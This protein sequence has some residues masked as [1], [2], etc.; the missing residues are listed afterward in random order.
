MPTAR[1]GDQLLVRE[2]NLSIILNTLSND[3]PGSRAALAAKT[4]LNKTTASSLVS[5][6]LKAQ[7]VRERGYLDSTGGRPGLLLELNRD[8][9]GIIA[10]EIGVDFVSVILANF[11]AEILWR[12][13]EP[14]QSHQSQKDILRR[15]TQLIRRA[16]REGEHSCA[17]LLGLGLG[18]P[19]LV[20]VGSGALVFAPNLGWR[21]VPLK[22][23]LERQFNFPVFVGNEANMGAM[24]ETYF[25][26]ARG[27]NNVLY[28]SAGVGL[29]GS[30]VLNGQILP[31]ATGYA[32]E[33]GHMTM[34]PEG[35]RCNCGNRG[36]WETLV[37]QT[38][39]LRRV[40]SMIESG[41]MSI[42]MQMTLGQLD[43]MTI[44]MITEAARQ[45]DPVGREALMETGEYLGIGIANLINA[46]N[47]ELVVFGGILSLAGDQLLPVI[48]R[49][50]E[51]RALGESSAAT[52]VLVAAHGFDACVIGGIATV[53]HDILSEPHKY[54]RARSAA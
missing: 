38:A 8:V 5:E 32:G 45:D 17:R 6:L 18:V 2:I 54:I 40:R 46:F 31:G 12:N 41:Q 37:S 34:D 27:Y 14:T 1:T 7:L 29:G 44:P 33:I 22:S 9:G 39:V 10:A 23:L 25:G 20:D 13:Q 16:V 52:Q 19:G 53:Y 30:V 47:P 51:Q 42:L 15:A 4:G 24:G 49:V 3:G 36:C 21:D 26:V 43:E 11:N 50:V 48:H 35:L 28:I